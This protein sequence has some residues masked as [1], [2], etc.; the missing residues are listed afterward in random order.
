MVALKNREQARSYK[1]IAAQS[2][3]SPLFVGASS[4]AIR[5]ASAEWTQSRHHRSIA[6]KL[7][8]SHSP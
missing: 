1:L 7:A 4:L 2:E 8:I 6:C 5:R 3:D